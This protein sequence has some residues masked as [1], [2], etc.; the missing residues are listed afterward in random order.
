[1]GSSYA[2][3]QNISHHMVLPFGTIFRCRALGKMHHSTGQWWPFQK[4]Y[5]RFTG[6][7]HCLWF[8]GGIH[9]KLK[10]Q[11]FDR[12]CE[13]W[14][15]RQLGRMPGEQPEE[16]CRLGFKFQ[17][18]HSLDVWF[19]TNYSKPLS[20]SFLTYKT[21]YNNMDFKGLLWRSQNAINVM[22]PKHGRHSINAISFFLPTYH[23]NDVKWDCL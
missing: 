15:R 3:A 17:L 10:K 18:Y 7:P 14:D 23:L 11:S 21:G 8:V 1:M 9:S 22:W 4:I 16:F 20:L 19:T 13:P 12:S 2:S 5:V 6:R